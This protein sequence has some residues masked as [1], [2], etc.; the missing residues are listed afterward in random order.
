[1]AT[2]PQEPAQKSTLYLQ[3]LAAIVLGVAV[4]HLAPHLGAA[5]KPLGDGF[6]RLIKMLVAPLVFSTVVVGIASAGDLKRVGRVGAKALLYF[7]VVT[8]AALGIG[9]IVMHVSG[10]TSTGFASSMRR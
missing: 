2:T 5:L 1:M 3:V 8:T 9:L 10:L 4:G 6:V 7:E